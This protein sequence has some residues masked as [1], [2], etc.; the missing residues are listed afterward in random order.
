[1]IDGQEF[2]AE[3]GTCAYIPKDAEHGF[4]NLG[5]QELRFICIVPEEGDK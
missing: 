2:P 4:K 5:E 1:M 3:V